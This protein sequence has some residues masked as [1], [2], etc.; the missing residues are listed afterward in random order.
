MVWADQEGFVLAQEAHILWDTF[1]P[2]SPFDEVEV[3]LALL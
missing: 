2:E 3:F 1:V